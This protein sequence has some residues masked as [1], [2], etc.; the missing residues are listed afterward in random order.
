MDNRRSFKTNINNFLMIKEVPLLLVIVVSIV[1]LSIVRPTFFSLGNIKAVFLG[2]SFEM[3]IAIGMTLLFIMGGFDLSVGS[4][5][6]F[7][8]VMLGMAINWGAGI[9][10]GIL[11][12]I[13]AA[14]LVGLI[15]GLVIAK[16]KVNALIT[17]LAM[18]SIVR[19][20]IYILTKGVG[21]P[22]LP[23]EF[24]QLGRAEY[25]GI[26][27]PIYVAFILMIVF[28][29]LFA[30][31]GWFRQYYFIGGNEEAARLSGIK[32]DRLRVYAYTFTGFMGG[33]AGILLAARMG[34]A[35]PT[36]GAGMEMNIIAGCVIGGSSLAGGEGTMFG[37]FLGMLIMALVLNAFNI[38]GVDIYW[39]RLILGLILL[40]AVLGDVFRKRK[41]EG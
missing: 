32:V 34:G 41:L 19:G 39:Q 13:G 9:P 26:Q 40:A 1:V 30:R 16:L 24:N 15:N 38:L 2:S 14:T 10:G 20:I 5:A 11:F 3:I 29:I 4:V 33:L 21:K 22:N 6:G 7:S 31:S 35:I 17:T 12:G 23:D 25:F 18:Q 36:Q 28:G 37:S 8:G 27:T